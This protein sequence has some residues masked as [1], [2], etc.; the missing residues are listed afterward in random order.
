MNKHGCDPH[1]LDVEAR[2]YLYPPVSMEVTCGQMTIIEAGH[3][4]G[5]APIVTGAYF[6]GG[7]LLP[8][9]AGP[10]GISMRSYAPRGEALDGHWDPPPVRRGVAGGQLGRELGS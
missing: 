5:R 3:I 8:A 4:P 10:P 7:Q 9:P 2:L 1:Q 6:G